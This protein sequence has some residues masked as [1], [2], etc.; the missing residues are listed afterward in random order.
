MQSPSVVVVSDGNARAR[1]WYQKAVWPAAAAIVILGAGLALGVSWASM[2]KF[3]P[4]LLFL[5]CPA[6]HFFMCRSQKSSPD[7]ADAPAP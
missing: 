7:K 1:G 2:V 3:S 6:M 5:A 4:Y